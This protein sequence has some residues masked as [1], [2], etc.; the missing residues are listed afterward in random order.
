MKVVMPVALPDVIELRK[1][2]GADQWDEMW[3]G[4]LHMPPMANFDHQDLEVALLIYLWT[5][6]GEPRKAKVLH[7]INL[8]APGGWPNNYRI[9][10][11]LLLTRERFDINCGEYFEGAP[12][13]V[14]EI[15]SPGD[16]SY[17]KLPF[18]ANLDVPEV[19]IIDRDTKEPEVYLLK[20][21]R[22][23]KQAAGTD[24]WV[25]SPGTDLE[26]KAGLPG[27]LAVRRAGDDSTR[28]D[29]PED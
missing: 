2:T 29:L 9:P 15:R 24:G 16:E 1:R 7:Q 23:K 3:E 4:V 18:Y 19:W 5:H 12:D 21:S 10:D 8:A 27:K 26:L 28:A 20:R 11:L 22:Y 14:V 13:L 6:W 25:H 17:E